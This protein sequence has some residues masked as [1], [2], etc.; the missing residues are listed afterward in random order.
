[1]STAAGLAAFLF[2]NSSATAGPFLGSVLS[3]AQVQANNDAGWLTAT[4]PLAPY[5][6]ASVYVVFRETDSVL[7]FD[8]GTPR[9]PPA[10]LSAGSLSACAGAGAVA[11]GAHAEPGA[12]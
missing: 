2:L 5:V 1:V 12:R 6:G 10:A 4:A 11:G 3:A 7:N 8:F 9:C